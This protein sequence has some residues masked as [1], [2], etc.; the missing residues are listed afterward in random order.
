MG[1]SNLDGRTIHAFERID[2]IPGVRG[3]WGLLSNL[4]RR[5]R[6]ELQ[7]VPGA[8]ALGSQIATAISQFVRIRGLDLLFKQETAIVMHKDYEIILTQAVEGME[9]RASVVA[10]VHLKDVESYDD[11]KT[12][13]T[14]DLSRNTALGHMATD[15]LANQAA[16]RLIQQ[17]QIDR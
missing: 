10:V 4:F 8:D 12:I 14:D 5:S 6:A 15:Y 1:S 13:Q 9:N 17:I 7:R 16:R 11:F 3:L 2:N